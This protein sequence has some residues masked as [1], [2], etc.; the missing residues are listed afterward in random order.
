MQ[1]QPTLVLAK[2]FVT[3]PEGKILLLRRSANA[4]RRALGWDLPGGTVELLEDPN[5]AVLRE[6]KE[7][8][9]LKTNDA[10]IFEVATQ[11][12]PKY[13]LTLIYVGSTTDTSVT[14]SDEHDQFQWI[15]LGDFDNYD[16]QEKYI[17]A[18]AS[19]AVMFDE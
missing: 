2:I 16:M 15:N 10:M 1:S 14:L 3:N 13:I 9:G 11:T 8:S 17:K 19:L 4:P 12:D 5:E 6:L 7:E 18:A